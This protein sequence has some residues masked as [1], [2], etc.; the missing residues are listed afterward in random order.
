MAITSY[1]CEVLRFWMPAKPL[2]TCESNLLEQPDSC[3]LIH[4]HAGTELPM[5]PRKHKGLRITLSSLRRAVAPSINVPS[6]ILVWVPFPSLGCSAPSGVFAASLS[7]LFRC[8]ALA[9]L[10][11]SITVS[12]VVLVNSAC[13]HTWISQPRWGSVVATY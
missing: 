3:T 9:M 8:S 13:K 10:L 2:S 7:S 4:K 12:R 6:G 1:F 5:C 11:S